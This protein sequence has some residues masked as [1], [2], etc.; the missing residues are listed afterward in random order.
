MNVKRIAIFM[1][2]ILLAIPAGTITNF[3]EEINENFVNDE[4]SNGKTLYVGGNGPNNYTG[5]QDAV[6]AAEDGDTIIVYSKTYRENIVVSKSL[7]IK[8]VKGKEKPIIEPEKE[9]R[10][11]IFLIVE[12]C[13]IENFIIMGNLYMISYGHAIIN[14]AFEGNGSLSSPNT[15]ED[16][17]AYN[18]FKGNGY[19]G[20]NLDDSYI[21]KIH[22]NIFVGDYYTGIYLSSCGKLDIFN[23]IFHSMRKGI[24]GGDVY[25][26]QIYS[27]EFFNLKEDGIHISP[28]ASY[29]E[30]FENKIFQCRCG[31]HFAGK[32]DNISHNEIYNNSLG[33][34]INCGGTKVFENNITNNKIGIVLYNVNPICGGA[35]LIFRNNFINNEKQ[36][37]FTDAYL[38]IWYNNYWSN[39]IFPFLKPIFGWHCIF[40]PIILFICY[41]WIQFDLIPSLK[42]IEWWEK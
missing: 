5:I 29:N 39:W 41:P 3:H 8:G 20:I 32:R 22:D 2:F 42:P 31:I 4:I 19:S 33:I 34:W 7:T 40:V 21:I 15:V 6:N 28:S 27:N 10:S 24:F 38:N 14:N 11:A 37:T 23:N 36:A 1:A 35:T 16:V 12:N 30:I 13:R 25:E 18:I 17:I 9:N 26:L